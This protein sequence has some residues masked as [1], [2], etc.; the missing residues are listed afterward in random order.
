MR[1]SGFG[2]GAVRFYEELTANNNRTWWHAN[3]AWYE[4]DVRAPLES[5]L[6]DLADE[7]GEAKVFRPH[8]DTRFSGNKDPYKPWAA[9]A[10][11][12]PAGAWYMQLGADGLRIA[13]GCYMPARDQL[14]KLRELIADDHR[15]PE[16]IELVDGLR[17]AGMEVDSR[18][19]LKT[20]PR[21]YPVDHPRIELLR[22]KGVIASRAHAPGPWVQTPA[23]RDRVVDGWH[24]LTPLNDWLDTHVGPTV[25][26]PPTRH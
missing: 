13:G 12:H 6:A 9:A 5:L 3:K 19:K 21:G 16:L 18:D 24:T 25:L 4:A 20:A 22:M 14:A 1:F 11:D 2:D 23:F 10:I 26:A 17:K 8:R 15:G 7:F